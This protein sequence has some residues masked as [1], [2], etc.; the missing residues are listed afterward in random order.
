[1]IYVK[2]LFH[3]FIYHPVH[4]SKNTGCRSWSRQ[5]P[6]SKQLFLG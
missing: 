4:P 6:K 1:L 3:L 2:H 5:T